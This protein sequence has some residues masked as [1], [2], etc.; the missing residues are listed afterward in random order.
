MSIV[1]IHKSSDY[2]VM[3]NY[4]FKEKEMSLKA[5]G[6]L[7][8]MLS[9]PDD[10]DYSIAG[11]TTL[12]KDGETS[13][14]R[15]LQEL[16]QFGYLKRK[17]VYV[18]G[19]IADW[20]YNIFESPRTENLVVENQLVG[21]Q[22]VEN[23]RQ[24]KT[25]ESNTKES[26][27]KEDNSKE[28]YKD[29]T[30]DFLGSAKKKEP[31]Q[32]L[33]SKCIAQIDSRDYNTDLHNALVDYL[34]VRLQ[35][36]D[37]QLYANSWKGLLNKLERDF[38]NDEERLQSVYQSIERGY[39]SFFPVNSSRRKVDKPWEEGVTSV[40]HTK[41]EKEEMERWQNEMRRKGIQVDF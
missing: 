1:R 22:L 18:E 3:S 8:M 4:H 24:L 28:L 41:Q 17:R 12:S 16:E 2:T 33:Y 36:K 35:I 34:Q 14:K 26:K 31:S 6:L 30:K 23:Q 13:V 27:T 5:K 29:R 39:A 38:T 9:L 7:S 10:W 21:F 32:S 19:K 15:T 20:E 37:K 25:K 11:L 40:K